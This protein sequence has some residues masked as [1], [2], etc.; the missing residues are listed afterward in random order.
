MLNVAKIDKQE[1]SAGEQ[2]GSVV[3]EQVSKRFRKTTLAK[4]SYDTFKSGVVGGLR[5]SHR[6]ADGYFYALNDITVNL[7]PG[8]SVGIIGRNGSGKSTLLKLIAGIYHPDSGRV[9]VNG[10]LSALIELGAGFHPDFSGRENVYL[11]GIMYGLSRKEIDARFNDIVSFAELEDFIDD[12][13]RTYSSGMYMRLGFSLAIH[14]DPDVLL[15]DEVLAVGDAS[16]V[17]RCHD[18]ISEFR[19]KGK[20]LVFVTHDLPSVVRWCDEAVWLDKGV[21]RKRGN[22][23]LVIDSYLGALKD[24]EEQ[25]LEYDNSQRHSLQT[26]APKDAAT[27]CQ[28]QDNEHRWGSREVEILNVSI[29]DKSDSKRWIFD[30]DEPV[31]I[32]IEYVVNS[33]VEDLVFGIG[34]LRADGAVVHGT[35]TEIEDV[36]VPIASRCG[37][38]GVVKYVIDA[39]GLVEDTYYIDVAAH[40][41]D[42][43]A[44]DYHHQQY[45]FVVRCDK[46]YHGIWVPAHRWE[47][48]NVDGV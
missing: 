39:L 30:T 22:P 17:H 38:R 10:K 29:H 34:V 27:A 23:K 11:G 26:Q 35:N 28:R 19:R 25:F 20:T 21:V 33:A 15:V 8:Q 13:V 43:A 36:K 4:K 48:C 5:L 7:S 18:V 44:Y 42:G 1:R 3:V 46:R 32:E 45:K 6:V 37:A 40:R 41:S 47:F 31:C 12:P 2:K 24:D 9:A 14:T 16:F